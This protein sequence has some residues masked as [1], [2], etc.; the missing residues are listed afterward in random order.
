MIRSRVTQV[1]GG[2][3][4]I[5]ARYHP[6][7]RFQAYQWSRGSNPNTLSTSPSTSSACCLQFPFNLAV[8]ARP[9]RRIWDCPL[10]GFLRV[11]TLSSVSLHVVSKIHAFFFA[12]RAF[13]FVASLRRA[14]NILSSLFRV[15]RGWRGGRLRLLRYSECSFRG[16]L[17]RHTRTR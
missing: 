11:E 7:I 6:F 10:A 3:Q 15:V 8:M 2:T 4:S 9:N 1:G 5:A 13:G 17:Q 14:S 16:A 12:S